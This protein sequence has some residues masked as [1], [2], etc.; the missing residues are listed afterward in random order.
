MRMLHVSDWHI[1]RT[2]TG[3]HSR[4]TEFEAVLAEIADIAREVKP[5]LIVNT[6]DLFDRARPAAA[7][8]GLGVRALVELAGVAPTVVVGGNHDSPALLQALDTLVNALAAGENGRPPRLRFIATA[9]NA[10]PAAV[11]ILTFPSDDGHRIRLAPL[12]FVHRNRALAD[13]DRPDEAGQVYAHHLRQIQQELANR[14]RCGHDPARDVLIMAAH[15]F[16]EGALPSHS[17]RPLDIT[18]DYACPADALPAVTYYALG[19]I[20]KPQA[21][22]R[23]GIT[24]RYAGSPLQLDFGEEGE[25]KS[26]V[27]VEAGPARPTRVETIALRS[28]RRLMTFTGDLH[29]LAEQ[30]E[31]IGDAFVKAVIE[32]D[33]A[34]LGLGLSASV[35]AIIPRATLVELDE[36]LPGWQDVPLLEARSD[37]T[38][39]PELSESF[40][41]YLTE[42]GLTPQHAEQ[43]QHA[44]T[45]LLSDADRDDD[46]V[47]TDP[48][49]QMLRDALPAGH[50]RL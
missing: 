20:H 10:D 46:H 17:E 28:G 44:F 24:A 5:D 29:R 50:D 26:V 8:L 35:R 12:P 32:V 33:G 49:E 7:D 22:G 38:P 4:Y 19:H 13:C 16:V 6:G 25:T 30:A 41:A 21:I 18:Q 1:G 47:T 42:T 27:L 43:L 45:A 9:A 31:D 36:R 37:I 40:L 11:S 34:G 48:V 14:L 39:E 3:N 23:A 2:V 15:L